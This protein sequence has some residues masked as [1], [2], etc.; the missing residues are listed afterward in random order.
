MIEQ[1]H[2]VVL[3][4]GA[5]Q[6]DRVATITEAQCQIEAMPEVS[7][8]RASTL[9]ETV[10]LT[11]NGRDEQAPRYL[12]AVATLTTS[13]DAETLLQRLQRIE[14][15]LERVRGERWADRTIDIDIVQFG[16]TVSREAHLTL[17][18]P[19]AHERDF[20]LAP[21][22]ELDPDAVLLGRGRVADLLSRIGD[23]TSRF[24]VTP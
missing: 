24:E 7:E 8:F 1:L 11:L 19:H 17:P 13:L 16:G 10:A 2:R 5:N 12:N 21:W 23:T 14:D 6:G 3:A 20:V 9:R 15:D 18:H 4:F 22:L